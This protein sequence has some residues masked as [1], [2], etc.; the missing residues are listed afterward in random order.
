[1]LVILFATLLELDF[2]KMDVRLTGVDEACGNDTGGDGGH[3]EERDEDTDDLAWMVM[4]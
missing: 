4:G 1:M 2:D 3:A